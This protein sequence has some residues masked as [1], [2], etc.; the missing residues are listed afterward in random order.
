MKK[1][2]GVTPLSEEEA[3]GIAT[4]L[5][6]FMASSPEHMAQFLA[7]SGMGPDDVR[8]EARSRNFQTAMLE[9]ILANEA[10]LLSFCASADI[11]PEL[12]EP[13]KR[14]LAGEDGGEQWM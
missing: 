12:I 5:L 9:H 3:S 7:L 1:T 4:R 13:A 8:R 10:L 6:T 2:G 14:A 11:A